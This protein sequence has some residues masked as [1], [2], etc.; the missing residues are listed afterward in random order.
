MPSN[1]SWQ[2]R[3]VLVTG[4]A[5]GIGRATAATLADTGARVASVDV[6]TDGVPNG[7]F[8]LKADVRSTAEIEEAIEAITAQ[9]G[10]LD[11]LVNNVGVSFVGGVEDGEIE[12]W[13]RVFDIN[14]LGTVRVTRAALPHLRRSNSPVIVNVSSCT[15]VNGIGSRSLYSATKGALHS[16]TMSMAV[17]LLSDGIR[18]NA[19]VPGTVDTEFMELL[20]Q[21]S[22]DPARARAEFGERQPT[23]HMVHPDEVARAIQ[24]LADPRNP[25]LAGT[26]LTIDGGM[27]TLRTPPIG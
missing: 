14:V 3:T 5:S 8:A 26:C 24:F 7:V 18:V 19:V 15:A 16:M 21:R 9:F 17:D 11:V 22:D 27:A 12:D 6:N 23:G 10:G 20:A 1:T 25:S 4:G 2:N 13:H